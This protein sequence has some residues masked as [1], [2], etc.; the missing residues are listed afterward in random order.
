MAWNFQQKFTS[1]GKLF[2]F[3]VAD[4]SFLD[5]SLAEKDEWRGSG[6]G[7]WTLRRLLGS[8][9]IQVARR[10]HPEFRLLVGITRILVVWGLRVEFCMKRVDPRVF[11][12]LGIIPGLVTRRDQ[13][14]SRSLVGITQ[15]FIGCKDHTEEWIPPIPRENTLNQGNKSE[16]K[17]FYSPEFG[18]V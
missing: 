17:H 1:F 14:I 10:D 8:P 15:S 5:C 3:F 12:L 11:V 18:L 9:G 4:F 6:R 16:Y 2:D 13:P 7:N